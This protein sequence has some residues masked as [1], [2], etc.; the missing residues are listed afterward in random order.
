MKEVYN[1]IKLQYDEGIKPYL[2]LILAEA[3]IRVTQLNYLNTL[4]RVLVSKLEVERATGT[5]NVSA[6]EQK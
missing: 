3:E 2:D 4:Y 1:I 5:I 6:Y